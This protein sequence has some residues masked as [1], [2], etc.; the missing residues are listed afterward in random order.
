M[1]NI[2][3]CIFLNLERTIYKSNV[4]IRNSKN[5]RIMLFNSRPLFW[6]LRYKLTSVV[7]VLGTFVAN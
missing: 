2:N 6:G 1:D 5:P 4:K 3:L 7:V